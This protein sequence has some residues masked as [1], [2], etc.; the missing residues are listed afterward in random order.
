MLTVEDART[1]VRPRTDQRYLFVTDTGRV[2]RDVAAVRIEYFEGRDILIGL[3]DNPSETN[4]HGKIERFLFLDEIIY[5]EH[6]QLRAYYPFRIKIY[7]GGPKQVFAA[8]WLYRVSRSF[9]FEV[10][11][12]I[13]RL[14]GNDTSNPP[15]C[16]CEHTHCSS[17]TCRSVVPSF[18]PGGY[19]ESERTFPVVETA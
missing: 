1:L 4:S 11:N 13:M 18:S 5:W 2:Y 6:D 10:G 17:S 8:E 3:I 16:N 19:Q 12:A 7:G 14:R 9:S 15:D